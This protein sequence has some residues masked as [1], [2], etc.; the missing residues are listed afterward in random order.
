MV[1]TSVG[2]SPVRFAAIGS[3]AKIDRRGTLSAARARG[4]SKCSVA[5]QDFDVRAG[6]LESAE[7][8]G[9]F[10]AAKTVAARQE[11]GGPKTFFL[12]SIQRAAQARTY[13]NIASC[14][15]VVVGACGKSRTF[16]N[17]NQA[18]DCAAQGQA[19]QFS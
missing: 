4:A 2:K 15:G 13:T 5:A 16:G 3:S 10:S 12:R 11:G 9:S 7:G 6:C 14:R 18:R 19:L 1:L 17:N 8:L